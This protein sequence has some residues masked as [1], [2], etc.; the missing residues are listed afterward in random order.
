MNTNTFKKTKQT[1]LITN[2]WDPHFITGNSSVHGAYTYTL[3]SNG[4]F[5]GTT[6]QFRLFSENFE[7][8]H[9]EGIGVNLLDSGIPKIPVIR[10]L[11]YF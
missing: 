11:Q 3:P 10:H 9:S 8:L 4:E 2:V 1:M 6:A 7:V 5:K